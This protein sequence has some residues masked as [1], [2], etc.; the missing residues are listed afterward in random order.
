MRE[1]PGTDDGSE[2]HAGHRRRHG[3]GDPAGGRTEG[4]AEVGDQRI[5]QPSAAA[6]PRNRITRIEREG[7]GVGGK[8]G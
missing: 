1:E 3:Q 2:G 7:T 8:G 5:C 6:P 4:E